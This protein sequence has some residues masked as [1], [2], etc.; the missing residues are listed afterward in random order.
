MKKT[1]LIAFVVFAQTLLL[2]HSIA[3]SDE[4]ETQKQSNRVESNKEISID[5]R[6]IVLAALSRYEATSDCKVLTNPK[7]LPELGIDWINQSGTIDPLKQQYLESTAKQGVYLRDILT[8]EQ[9]QT[10]K[11]HLNCMALEGILGHETMIALKKIKIPANRAILEDSVYLTLVFLKEISTTKKISNLYEQVKNVDINKCRFWG[12]TE[13][14]MCGN[15][16]LDLK[17][18]ALTVSAVELFPSFAGVSGRASY[19]TSKSAIGEL[20]T[21]LL[22]TLKEPR[23]NQIT[24]PL[25]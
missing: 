18:I 23:P 1:F 19:A 11:Q 13:T 16:L 24:I 20:S 5:L 22:N 8:Y 6:S 12:S 15:V 21:T 10:L 4:Q 7:F 9:L 2:N 25:K 17:R 14:I 3:F